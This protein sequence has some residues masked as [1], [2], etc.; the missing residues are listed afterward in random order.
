M[1]SFDVFER[2]GNLAGPGAR[3]TQPLG[4]QLGLWHPVLGFTGESGLLLSHP[5]L[6][7]EV[8]HVQGAQDFDEIACGGS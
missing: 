3:Q 1:R 7:T 8:T 4:D 5:V 2:N 6:G